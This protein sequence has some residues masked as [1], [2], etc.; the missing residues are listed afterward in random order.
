MLGSG[1][2]TVVRGAS[3]PVE[4]N[5]SLKANGQNSAKF[6]VQT[7]GRGSSDTVLNLASGPARLRFGADG[8]ASVAV[9]VLPGPGMTYDPDLADD[10]QFSTE[11][12]FDRP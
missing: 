6:V 1:F 8:R 4:L 9:T 10:T 12:V 2:I 3:D 5:V 7:V 11:L